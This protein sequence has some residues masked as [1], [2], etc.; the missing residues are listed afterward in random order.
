MLRS[1]H[2]RT[3]RRLCEVHTSHKIPERRVVVSHVNVGYQSSV[4]FKLF[5]IKDEQ[6]VTS[7]LR[8][9]YLAIFWHRN[10]TFKSQVE[11]RKLHRAQQYAKNNRIYVGP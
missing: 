9:L 2:D 1:R 4:L 11:V 3:N 7:R 6:R 10:H 8:H 5:S